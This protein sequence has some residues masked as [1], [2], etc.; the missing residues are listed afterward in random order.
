[1]AVGVTLDGAQLTAD[2][3][4]RWKRIEPSVAYLLNG[5]TVRGAAALIDERGYFIAHRTV[6]GTQ[7]SI[8]GRLSDGTTV[9][10]RLAGS[11]EAT[12]LVLLV[13]EL[14][15]GSARPANAIAQEKNGE[16]LFAVLPDGPIRAELSAGGKLGVLNPSRRVL[17]LSEVRFEDPSQVVG[18]ALIFT[19]SG[20]FM[21][22]LNATLQSS[23]QAT[24][25]GFDNI[26]PGA[27]GSAKAEAADIAKRAVSQRYGPAGLTV[28][29]TA[30]PDALRRVIDGFRSPSRQVAHP[31]LGVFCR[32]AG[33]EGAL[34]DSITP[35]SPAFAS[36]LLQ[37]DI[38]V[39]MAGVPISNQM[40]YARELL[41]QTVGERIELKY[42]RGG[43][44]FRLT[45]I[46][47][48]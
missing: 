26:L 31:A 37:G 7:S 3:V 25:S 48:K 42:R 29:Y 6:V 22:A 46:V 10:L 5:A 40:D 18:G 23:Q 17:S 24:K 36:G 47:G 27:G 13:A 43:V 2:E 4:Q 30:G 21:G 44:L 20:E 14:W 45:L 34:V 1:M 19:Q 9:R 8:R 41:R 28:A 16:R 39:E 35:G 33:G 38:I 32:D 12:Q 11:D 15:T